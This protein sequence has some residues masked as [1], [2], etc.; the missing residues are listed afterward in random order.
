MFG[1]WCLRQKRAIFRQIFAFLKAHSEATQLKKGEK[2]A[3][4]SRFLAKRPNP[5]HALN[6]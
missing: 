4:K 5:K 6:G 1:I 2:V 3:E